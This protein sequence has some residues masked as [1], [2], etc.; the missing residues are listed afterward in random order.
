MG[1]HETGISCSF[2][3]A[4]LR[5]VGSNTLVRLYITQCL[6]STGTR[7]LPSAEVLKAAEDRFGNDLQGGSLG[8]QLPSKIQNTHAWAACST[9][10]NISIVSVRSVM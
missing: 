3:R 1:L 6:A 7:T 10:L 8:E 9:I 4:D 2:M 5:G